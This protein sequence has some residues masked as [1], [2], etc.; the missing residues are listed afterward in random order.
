MYINEKII[1]GDSSEHNV[2]QRRDYLNPMSSMSDC[3]LRRL[4][5]AE[6]SKPVCND[7]GSY[8]AFQC[9]SFSPPHNHECWCVYENGQMIKGKFK[10]IITY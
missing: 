6:D 9:D 8:Q 2:H 3:Q 5:N 4:V 1:L 7:D 10:I